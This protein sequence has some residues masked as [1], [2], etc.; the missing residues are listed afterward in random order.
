MKKI[1]FF[2][3]F[4]IVI[5]ALAFALTACGGNGKND[6]T[7]QKPSQTVEKT[8]DDQSST[9]QNSETEINTEDSVE[10][11]EAKTEEKTTETDEYE[12]ITDG[13]GIEFPEVPV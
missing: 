2:R 11:T 8:D 1:A 3:F 13:P 12:Y 7:E 5:L 6:K 10:E 9:N 4:V